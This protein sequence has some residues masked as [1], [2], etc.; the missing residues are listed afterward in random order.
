ML[1]GILS[2]FMAVLDVSIMSWNSAYFLFMSKIRTAMLPKIV[3]FIT[4]PRVR[5]PTA[6][7][8]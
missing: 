4:A 2:I 1:A 6:R 3:A 5:K 7:K 8:I